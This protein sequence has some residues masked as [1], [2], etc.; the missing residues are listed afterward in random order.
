MTEEASSWQPM[1]S[2]E[3]MKEKFADKELTTEQLEDVAGGS[4]KEISL[5]SYFLYHMLGRCC[6]PWDVHEQDTYVRVGAY[7]DVR[8]AWKKL[9][10]DMNIWAEARNEYFIDGKRISRKQAF[11]HA[12]KV[13]GKQVKDSDWMP[14]K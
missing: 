3:I 13:L 12:Q 7:A 2:T 1:K 10:V 4:E 8:A 11:E 14:K 6:L 9:G 5:D